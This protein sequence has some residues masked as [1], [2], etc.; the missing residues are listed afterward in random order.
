MRRIGV[1]VGSAALVLLPSGRG[2]LERPLP[3]HGPRPTTAVPL[4]VVPDG[5]GSRL[6]R[7]DPAALAVT[8]RSA[9]LGGIGAWTVSPDRRLVALGVGTTPSGERS[10]LRFANTETL[11]LV[12]RGV[13]LDGWLQAA[14]WGTPVRLVALVSASSDATVETIDAVAKT[15]VERRSLDGIAGEFARFPRGLA[16]LV[17]QPNT[18][19][20]VSLAVVGVDGSV[21]SARLDRIRAGWSWPDEQGTDPIGTTRDPALAVDPAGTAYVLDASGLVAAVDLR[22]LEV[23]YHSLAPASLVARLSN[24][25]TPVARAKGLTGPVRTAAWLGD[26]LIAL[27]GSDYSA[28]RARDGSVD[29]TQVPAGLAIV[30]THDWKTRTLDPQAYAVA[31][32]DG[33]LLATGGGWSSAGQG[34][35]EGLAV[36]GV[37]GTL[38][39]RLFPGTRPYVAGAVGGLA[40][41]QEDGDG[42]Y[43]VVD[44]ATGRIVR[45]GRGQAPWPLVG[46]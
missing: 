19:A 14:L 33:A 2:G 28:T 40:V 16:V 35:G 32:A 3:L 21:R 9:Q 13:A 20:T 36:Y 39:R 45:A 27:T 31:V 25:L 17:E 4:A 23:S 29:F 5:A 6:V 18:I 41:V 8:A 12:R 43:D 37:G 44:V 46:S 30:D 10:M 11:R 15:V 22:S 7:L 1:L 34:S 38:V 24:W 26:G 42:R